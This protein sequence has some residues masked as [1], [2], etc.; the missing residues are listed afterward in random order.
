MT[1][2]TATLEQDGDVLRLCWPGMPDLRVHAI[3]RLR[4][5]AL[6]REHSG[7]LP[8]DAQIR[9]GQGK[10]SGPTPPPFEHDAPLLRRGVVSHKG[11]TA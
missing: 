9:D 7:V 6:D 2:P 4:D 5:N 8:Q 3:R 11:H 1:T 10:I